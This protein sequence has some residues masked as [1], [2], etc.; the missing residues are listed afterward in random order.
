[1]AHRAKSG[2]DQDIWNQCTHGRELFTRPMT[3]Q[4]V[5]SVSIWLLTNVYCFPSAPRFVYLLHQERKQLLQL[6]L[7]LCWACVLFVRWLMGKPIMFSLGNY[8]TLMMF[9]C[10]KASSQ[11]FK[12]AL[13]KLF[14]STIVAHNHE[15]APID[16]KHWENGASKRH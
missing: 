14:S 3:S 6:L 12:S 16:C 13:P 2:N 9:S 1:M 7:K 8:R 4:L 11:T 15:N 10:D 5:T